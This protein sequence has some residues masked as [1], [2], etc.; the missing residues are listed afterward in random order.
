MK[1][2]KRVWPFGSRKES[3]AYSMLAHYVQG[4]AQLTP[5]EYEKLAREGYHKNA[6]AYRCVNLIAQSVKS[7]KFVLYQEQADGTLKEIEAHP[8]LKLLKKPN[9]MMAGPKYWEHVAAYLQLSGNA[10]THA[11]G[12]ENGKAPRE[13]WP[14]RPDTVRVI[15]GPYAMPKAFEVNAGG[16]KKEFPVDPTG[17]KPGQFLHLK[18]FNPLDAWYG[19]SPIEAAAFSIDQ[20]NE[21]GAWNV[22]LMQNSA[23]PSGAF[24][25]KQPV[26]PEQRADIRKQ[27]EDKYQGAANAGK[28]MVLEGDVDFKPFSFSPKDM[29]WINSKDT[30]AR[31]IA[32]AFGVPSMLL[33]IPGDNTYANYQEARQAFWIETILPLVEDMLAAH[34]EWLLPLFGLK[35]HCLGFD[36]DQLDALSPSREALWKRINEAGYLTTN[37]K[38][39]ATG[40]EELDGEEYDDV[41][42]ASSQVPLAMAGAISEEPTD[43]NALADENGELPEGEEDP[44][45]VD[46]EKSWEHKVFNAR[47]KKRAWMVAQRRRK[48][49]ERRFIVQLKAV[50]ETEAELVAE[51]VDGLSADAAINA[52]KH[53]IDDHRSVFQRVVQQNLLLIGKDFGEATLRSAKSERLGLETKDQV[54][55]DH[56]L[57]EWVDQNTARRI[58][59]V[60]STT[61]RK[62]TAAIQEAF[63]A[64][65]GIPPMAKRIRDAY[66]GFSKSRAVLIA[67]TE[68]VSA[69]NAA[70]LGAAKALGI[71]NLEKEWISS[72]DER[73]R[74]GEPES[75]N[76]REMDGKRVDLDAKF[77][78]PSHDG[79]DLMEGPGDP[80]APVD[81]IANCRCTL[82]FVPRGDR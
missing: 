52:A 24:I 61:K 50:F 62:I 71:G 22:G 16:V 21:S 55:F 28:P 51:A 15:P 11:P 26:R 58:T 76:H 1:L 63:E 43:P 2:L 25:F 81:Q 34:S 23:R 64:N 10:Y 74:D 70:S 53:V 60:A 32:T 42:V 79:I 68:T 49:H 69:S 36:K 46:D 80:D 12:S 30:S 18:T 13:L 65:E 35:N 40:Y 54:R 27:L 6:I 77:E 44:E 7:I 56:Y 17:E 78:V 48:A 33:C 39:A 31:D 73:S 59:N 8:V 5:I 19:M 47:D 14:I 67:R 4:R 20:H 37:E 57:K 3:E 82:G 38:R 9:P 29:D 72:N 75:T 66:K 45:A 41:L